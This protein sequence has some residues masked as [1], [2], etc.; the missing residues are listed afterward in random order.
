MHGP[1]MRGV[2]MGQNPGS[3]VFRGAVGKGAEGRA[4]EQEIAQ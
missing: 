3:A 4:L 2:C 1:V